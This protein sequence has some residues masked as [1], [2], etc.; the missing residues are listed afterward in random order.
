MRIKL[1]KLKQI[2][3]EEYHSVTNDYL[4]SIKKYRPIAIRKLQKL[5]FKVKITNDGNLE[6]LSGDISRFYF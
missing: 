6:I 5:G 2:I 3:H 4:K 1:F